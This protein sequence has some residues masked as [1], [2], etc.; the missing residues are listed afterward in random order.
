MAIKYDGN[1]TSRKWSMQTTNEIDFK[2]KRLLPELQ[3]LQQEIIATVWAN[4]SF[5]KQTQHNNHSN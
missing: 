2:V 1:E 5:P 4:L 3:K